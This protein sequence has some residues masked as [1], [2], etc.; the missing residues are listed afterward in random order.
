MVFHQVFLLSQSEVQAIEILSPRNQSSGVNP[1]VE[2]TAN[3]ME[4]KS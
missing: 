1:L 4:E 3:S 2:V